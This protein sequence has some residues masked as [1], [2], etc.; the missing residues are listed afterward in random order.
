M[1]VV[2]NNNGDIITDKENTLI[3]LHIVLGVLLKDDEAT[4]WRM[5][6][7]ALFCL[8]TKTP[9]GLKFYT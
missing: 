8:L 6:C 1:Q 9:S 5:H 2:I 7:L 4:G 3:I